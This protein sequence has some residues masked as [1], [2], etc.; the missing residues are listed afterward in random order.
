L[1]QAGSP[2]SSA[3]KRRGWEWGPIELT[4]IASAIDGSFGDHHRSERTRS[5]TL[6]INPLMTLL[7]TFDLAAVARR[8]LYL[9]L[10]RETGSIW[11]VQRIIEGFRKGM[12]RRPRASIPH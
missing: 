2:L 12:E 7:W 4:S 6:F 10:L 9:H 3:A 1:E 8:S 11:D 5:S